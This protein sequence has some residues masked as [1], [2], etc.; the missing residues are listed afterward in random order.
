MVGRRAVLGGLA[1]CVPLPACADGLSLLPQERMAFSV[2]GAPGA[3]VLPAHRARVVARLPVAG[4]AATLLAFAADT[5]AARRDVLLIVAKTASGP[6][7]AALDLLSWRDDSGAH[8]TT[9]VASG[10]GRVVLT[11]DAAAPNGVTRWRRERWTDY[12]AW[13]DGFGLED[14]APRPPL[15]GT[16]QARLAA[17]RLAVLARLA[18]ECRDATVVLD[19]CGPPPAVWTEAA[20]RPAALPAL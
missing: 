18:R 1:A 2:A 4:G 11:R 16:F 19:Q 14:A 7:L 17:W 20:G 15:P 8:L 13:R 5:D 10:G 12:L 9:Q 6:R 3:I